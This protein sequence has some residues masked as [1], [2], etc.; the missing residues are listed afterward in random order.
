[1]GK[2]VYGLSVIVNMILKKFKLLSWNCRGLGALEKCGVVR[3][4]VRKSRCDICLF[5]E[6]KWNS[7]DLAHY[8]TALPSYFDQNCAVIDPISTSGGCLI[9]WRRN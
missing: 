1:M 5:Q 6:T 7:F 9:A 3:D 8:F 4:V 2:V